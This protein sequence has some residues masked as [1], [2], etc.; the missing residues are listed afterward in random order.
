LIINNLKIIKII[1][2]IIAI[3]FFLGYILLIQE[4]KKNDFYTLSFFDHGRTLIFYNTSRLIF[5]IYL[6][7]IIFSC[8]FSVLYLFSNKLSL[9]R[10]NKIDLFILG[11]LTG[12]FLWTIFLFIQ[13]IYGNLNFNLVYLFTIFVLFCSIPLLVNII[14][15]LNFNKKKLN[16]NISILGIYVLIFLTI[17]SFILFKGIYPN[18][19]SDYIGHYFFYYK[20][21]VET[22][23]LLPNEIWYHFYYS[24]GLALFFMGMLLTDPLAPQLIGSIYFLVSSLIIF[25]ILSNKCINRYIKFIGLL[26]FILFFLYT[27]G[28]EI[29]EM[30]GGWGDLEKT[31]ELTATFLLSLIWISNKL[32]TCNDSFYKVWLVGYISSICTAILITFAL[33]PIIFLYLIGFFI[34][35]F[36]NNQLKKIFW[37]VAGL[38]AAL[39][40]ASIILLINYLYTGLYTDQFLIKL[41]PFENIQILQNW[42][43]LFEAIWLHWN[44]MS[45]AN[46]A[47][48]PWNLKLFSLIEK[49]LRLEIWGFLFLAFFPILIFN[50]IH[51]KIRQSKDKYSIVLPSIFYELLWFTFVVIAA[52]LFGGGREQQIS[53]YRLTT[54]SYGPTLCLAL[55]FVAISLGFKYFNKNIFYKCIFIIFSLSITL[56]IIISP[57][58][59]IAIQSNLLQIGSDAIKFAKGEYS[60]KDAYQ[61]QDGRPGRTK[62][63]GIYEGI[64]PAWQIA[65]PNQ[66]IW[67]FHPGSTCMLPN[68]NLQSFFSTRITRHWGK[69]FFGSPKIAVDILKEEK[70]NYFFFSKELGVSDILPAAK[71]FSPQLIGQ[72][73]A[74]RWTDGNS[75]LLTWPGPNTSPI[76]DRFLDAYKLALNNSSLYKSFY[77]DLKT[78]HAISNYIDEHQNNLKPFFLPWCTNC[79]RMERIDYDAYL[80][81]AK[82]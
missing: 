7:W 48:A 53:F 55:I 61:H 63:G 57:V 11:V 69:V 74:I 32:R 59:L 51:L 60:L 9:G 46:L 24:K 19:G 15:H 6:T 80:N 39:V 5:S 14:N 13:G 22:G 68:C 34:F 41:W 76:D 28:P 73:L 3:I 36:Y 38:F 26:L 45:S 44:Y 2:W 30:N 66:R 52:S 67:T 56:F 40:S 21:V 75:Y 50:L 18:G 27:P 82:Y 64:I 23:S 31:H 43:V 58:K 12:S 17:L 35:Y 29:N 79:S 77:D 20:K 78:W 10:F 25:Q 71:L 33:F 81:K 47:A 70:L 16:C 8:G 1:P 37:T 42:G 4:Y 54:F 72:Y 62:W 65:G 49:Y